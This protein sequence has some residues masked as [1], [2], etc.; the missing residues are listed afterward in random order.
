MCNAVLLALMDSLVVIIC[1][2][3]VLFIL[4]MNED[5]L[6]CV[7]LFIYMFEDTDYVFLTSKISYSSTRSVCNTQNLGLAEDLRRGLCTLAG[8]CDFFKLAI[9]VI[10]RH[11]R[12]EYD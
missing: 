5:F 1:L 3:H 6:L 11:Q 4:S 10:F 9:T 7:I 12:Y 8:Y 2:N